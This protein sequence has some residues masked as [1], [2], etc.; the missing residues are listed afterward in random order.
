MYKVDIERMVEMAKKKVGYLRT[1][2]MGYLI[3]SAMAGIYLGF[4][5][6]LI[7][8]VGAP[9]WAEGSAGFKLVMGVSFGIAL[10][11]VIFAGS[12]LFTGN[13]MVCA[14]GALAKAITIKHVGLIFF[15]SFVGNLAG[16]LGLA[17]LVAQSGVVGQ[18]PQS[19]LLLKVASLKMNL[20]MWELFIRGILCN[21][22]VCLAVWTAART[23]NDAAKIMLIFWCLFAF[24]GSGFE[25]SIANQSLLGIALFLPHGPDV[26]WAGFIWNQVWVVSGN[27]VGGVVFMGGA[28]WITSP[29][30]G[31]IK[32]TETVTEAV[33]HELSR[34]IHVPAEGEYLAK[35][36]A[37]GREN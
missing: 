5:I 28:Y 18:A 31:W 36:L 8:S 35:P 19:D 2:P 9:F 14:F 26:S 13:N 3:L 27:I 1:N 33:A 16:S 32:K 30:H 21:W 12:E 20:P 4:G 22:L 23:T 25:H 37:V 17:W 6:C 7:F 11:L 34:R 29:V 24:I 10:T 15:W